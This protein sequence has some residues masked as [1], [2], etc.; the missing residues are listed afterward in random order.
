MILARVY[1]SC[2]NSTTTCNRILPFLDLLCLSSD[3]EDCFEGDAILLSEPLHY[4]ASSNQHPSPGA[5]VAGGTAG[6]NPPRKPQVFQYQYQ[7][8]LEE[9]DG[10][11]SDGDVGE[12][13]FGATGASGG[14]C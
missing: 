5:T 12:G 4:H 14:W 1:P 11:I 7:V 3:A 9:D 13:G 6:K 10:W 8:E 2:T